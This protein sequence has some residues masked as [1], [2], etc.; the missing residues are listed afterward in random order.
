[1]ELH[2]LSTAGM[3]GSVISTSRSTPPSDF[4]VLGVTGEYL[5]LDVTNHGFKVVLWNHTVANV[6]GVLERGGSN[7]TWIGTESA[8]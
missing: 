7:R 5:A 4:G 3:N 2:T 6:D 8:G 1:M